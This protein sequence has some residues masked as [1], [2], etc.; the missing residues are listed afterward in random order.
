MLLAVT[1]RSQ[2]FV[3]LN[4]EQAQITN[5]IGGEIPAANAFPGW[6]ASATFFVYNSFSL[7]G[8]S[9]S[10]MDTNA[11]F[12]PN[13]IQGKYFALFFGAGYS[14]YSNTPVS[15]SQTGLIPV[16]AKSIL[17]WGDNEGLAI[18]F[19]GSP[20]N[21]GAVSN[22]PNFTVYG[23]DISPYAGQV[24]LLSFSAPYGTQGFVDNIQFSST[25]APEP[26]SL[27]LAGLGTLL[28]LRL[29]RQP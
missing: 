17:F 22:A 7:S 13:Q 4:F 21:F 11:L 20:L 14:L 3:N 25:A 15:L 6:T 8:S 16:T 18:T 10:I 5:V 26:S 19:N 2:G 23:A 1:G 29:R 27:A 12:T 28:L 24:G 9:L